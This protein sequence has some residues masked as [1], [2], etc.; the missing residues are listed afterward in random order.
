MSSRKEP[1]FKEFL[2]ATRK[3]IGPGMTN[4]PVWVLQKAGKRIWNKKQ[5]RHWRKAELGKMFARSGAMEKGYINKNKPRT[6]KKKK[7]GKK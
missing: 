1:E 5:K 6:S 7:G 3:K 4:A 2:I